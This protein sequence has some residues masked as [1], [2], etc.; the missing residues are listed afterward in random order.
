MRVLHL[1]RFWH[2]KSGGI[3]RH[4][5]LLCKGLAAAGVDV[6]NLVAAKDA[7]SKDF[8]VDGVRTVEVASF[9]VAL[10]TAMAPLLPFK[11]LQ[12]HR[13]K[14]FDI[15]HLH[16]PD[17]LSHAAALL[18]PKS[19]KRVITWHSDIVRQK[20]AL[21]FYAPFLNRFVNGSDAVVAATQ[22]H[23]DSTTQIAPELPAQRRHVIAYGL[24]Y[25]ALALTERTAALRDALRAQAQGRGMVFALGRHVYYK[26]FDV[27]I[28]ALQH[29]SAFLVLGGD[30]PLRAQLQQQAETLGLQSRL[31]FAGLIPEADLAAYFHACDVFCLPSV[32]QSEAF[33]LVQLEAM[34]CGK[35]V[36]N[37]KL[38][39]GVN[40]VN[41]DGVTGLT[42]PVGDAP[43]LA[44][45]VNRLI[46]DTPL[47]EQLGGEAK[48]RAYACYSLVAS[49]QKH[50][51][52]YQ[53]LLSTER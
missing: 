40:V 22:A 1:G 9:G 46:A 32:E 14:P 34:A 25:S 51:E 23:F 48:E 47:R 52:L 18:L 7:Q 4:A 21:R 5:A 11:A 30:G 17:P 19:V 3:E 39:N 26:G 28:D 8:M 41:L 31:L 50:I 24:D 20:I 6:V 43:A 15:V 29:T 45:A 42:V 12:L 37:T 10:S 44:G 33:G 16:L 53:D 27:L 35:P 49:V 13:E 36:V 38:N 2:G